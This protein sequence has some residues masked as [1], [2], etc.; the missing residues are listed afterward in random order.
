ML[1][2][3]CISYSSQDA[4]YLQEFVKILT[5]LENAGII[6]SW[7]DQKLIPGQNWDDAIQSEFKSADV[8]ILLL[9]LDFFS[10]SYIN[11]IEKQIALDGEAH[12]AVIL[13]IFLRKCDFQKH[14]WLSERQGVPK[15]KW[16]SDF[17]SP[18]EKDEIYHTIS[19]AI[20]KAIE[21]YTNKKK[22]ETLLYFA[23]SNNARLLRERKRVNY[24]LTRFEENSEVVN[25]RIGPTPEEDDFLMDLDQKAYEEHMAKELESIQVFVLLLDDSDECCQW[26]FNAL[27]R[28]AE[29]KGLDSIIQIFLFYNQSEEGTDLNERVAE[30]VEKHD[31][32]VFH[33]L[34]DNS[35]DMTKI[36]THELDEHFQKNVKQVV[37]PGEK[38]YVT[39]FFDP[40]DARHLI[41]WKIKQRLDEDDEIEVIT[42]PDAQKV[43]VT[44]AM[45]SQSCGVALYY[46][47][48]NHNWF[49]TIQ[50]YLRKFFVNEKHIDPR[51]VFIDEPDA[52]V[53]D[54][55]FVNRDLLNNKTH[56]E[57]SILVDPNQAA[58][59]LESFIQRVKSSNNG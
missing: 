26:Q 57:V 21:Q 22:S 27:E 2:K 52:D 39:F 53:K 23:F 44:K 31:G 24:A 7:T 37:V 41:K 54:Q 43:S 34:C 25:F 16:V 49:D 35:A 51:I 30:F 42:R 14:G 10:S 17:Q 29:E 47:H 46:G 48:A 1:P 5:S 40:E 15:N 12:G 18:Q 9:S 3:V 28:H 4:A 55:M 45:L 58:S 20:G 19:Q 11:S 38:K 59:D 50:V 33:Q 32:K 36:I 56:K 6:S 8:Y 13:P